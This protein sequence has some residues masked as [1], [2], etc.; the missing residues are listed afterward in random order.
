MSFSNVISCIRA[1][2]FDERIPRVDLI[3]STV[4]SFFSNWLK[5][6]SHLPI[7][8][9]LPKIASKVTPVGFPSPT[10]STLAT[11][12]PKLSIDPSSWIPLNS[13]AGRSVTFHG[14]VLLLRKK[15]TIEKL[16]I[17][18]RSFGGT[19]ITFFSFKETK[20]CQRVQYK[21]SAF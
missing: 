19:V 14:Y 18:L 20:V 7:T 3:R 1:R 12:R 10:S 17:P 16:L 15:E 4:R 6:K 8:C 21:S 9:H 5:K 2:V 11:A 13:S